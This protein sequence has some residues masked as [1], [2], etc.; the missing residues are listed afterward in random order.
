MCNAN[1]SHDETHAEKE[2]FNDLHLRPVET[3]NTGQVGERD[4]QQDRGSHSGHRVDHTGFARAFDIQSKSPSSDFSK[5]LQR[6]N[7]VG[8]VQLEG[9]SWVYPKIKNVGQL[10]NIKKIISYLFLYSPEK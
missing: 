2:D 10:M 1:K 6:I 9:Q 4:A 8:R 3:D 5:L 7:T